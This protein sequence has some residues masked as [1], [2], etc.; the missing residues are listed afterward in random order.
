M[1][2]QRVETSKGKKID[3]VF[4]N[5]LRDASNFEYCRNT[6]MC[7]CSRVC[8]HIRYHHR[9]CRVKI[10]GDSPAELGVFLVDGLPP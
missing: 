2:A 9:E 1:R 10:R 5:C 8:M 7:V 3:I 6:Y 4:E